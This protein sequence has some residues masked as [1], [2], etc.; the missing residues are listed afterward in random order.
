[1]AVSLKAS[2]TG[3]E[4]IDRIRRRLGLDVKSKEIATG[5]RTSTATFLRFRQG[6]PI[7][8]SAFISICDFFEVD[9]Q[10][11]IDGTSETPRR[12]GG[13]K[14]GTSKGSLKLK[15]ESGVFLSPDQLEQ[16]SY[17]LFRDVEAI[18]DKL[19]EIS[20][21]S[22]LKWNS[23]SKG[24]LFIEIEGL[25][26]TIEM[27]EYL[28]SQGDLENL[29]GF[30]VLSFQPTSV[31]L[32]AWLQSNFDKALQ[33]GWQSIEDV[34]GTT[35]AQ[36]ADANITK[37]AKVIDIAEDVAITLLLSI[38][39]YSEKFF[40]VVLEVIP[41]GEVNP[42]LPIGLKLQAFTQDGELLEGVPES[43]AEDNEYLYKEIVELEQGEQ[44]RV[45]LTLEEDI[46]SE[47]FT[48]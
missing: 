43:S 1:M 17:E 41:Y 10:E 42:S 3:L 39:N 36:F 40:R 28:S 15:I 4:K 34:L 5:A 13:L 12:T 29:L 16:L 47:E 18:I 44:F 21:D 9:W 45:V 37:R 14:L 6:I 33:V 7:N 2:P 35:Q 25:L 23:V 46:Y 32:A 30:P 24:C 38:N 22:S 27:I 20:G 26:E 8:Q 31:N 11:I 19:R 48:I